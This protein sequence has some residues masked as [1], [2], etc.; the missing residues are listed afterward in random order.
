M[1]K[2]VNISKIS[3]Q[4]SQKIKKTPMKGMAAAKASTKMQKAAPGSP[5]MGAA[6][7]ALGVGVAGAR[8]VAGPWAFEKAK[9]SAAGKGMMAAGASRPMKTRKKT[10]PSAY[11]AK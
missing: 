3:A 6:K 11:K 9:G 10:S 8:G 5:R 1:A 2:G 7:A 4:R